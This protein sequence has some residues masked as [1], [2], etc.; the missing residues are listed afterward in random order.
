MKELNELKEMI[1]GLDELV[2]YWFEGHKASLLS[3]GGDDVY[4][5]ADHYRNRAL[6]IIKNLDKEIDK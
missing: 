2:G 3:A 1:L 6:E 5:E 4:S